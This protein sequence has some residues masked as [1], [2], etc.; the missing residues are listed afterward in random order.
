MP[1]PT[2]RDHII[3]MTL[4]FVQQTLNCGRDEAVEWLVKLSPD[5]RQTVLKM[6][7]TKNAYRANK[8]KRF[9]QSL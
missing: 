5:E 7:R 1:G 4:P 3:R 6:F 8:A 2:A 9:S